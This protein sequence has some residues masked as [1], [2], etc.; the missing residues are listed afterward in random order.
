MVYFL[1]GFREVAT[2]TPWLWHCEFWG[3]EKEAWHWKGERSRNIRVGQ[4]GLRGGVHPLDLNSKHMRLS[5]HDFSRGRRAHHM[6]LPTQI[7]KSRK[8]EIYP[9]IVDEIFAP[10]LSF[11]ES[12]KR[13]IHLLQLS[14]KHMC[15]SVIL[16]RK[17][18]RTSYLKGDEFWSR[19]KKKHIA[20]TKAKFS[21]HEF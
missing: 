10:C 17:S 7:F 19:E 3:R 18:P 6:S 13:Q 11:M 2:H 16:F 20:Q 5:A 12:L 9:I 8:E 14:S 4:R 21:H 1:Y 15:V